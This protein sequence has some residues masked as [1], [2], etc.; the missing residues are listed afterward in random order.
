MRGRS[1]QHR[2]GRAPHAVVSV[3]ACGTSGRR[4]SR[5]LSRR[6]DVTAS[7]SRSEVL[8]RMGGLMPSQTRASLFVPSLCPAEK[9]IL[10]E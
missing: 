4:L 3:S 7:G 1:Q 2:S 5:T 10:F 6:R 9:I 8:P